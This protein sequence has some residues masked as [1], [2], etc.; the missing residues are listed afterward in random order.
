MVHGMSRAW[1]A[2]TIYMLVSMTFWKIT[3]CYPF[4]KWPKTQRCS[5]C[6][7]FKVCLAILHYSWPLCYSYCYWPKGWANFEKRSWNKRW[8]LRVWFQPSFC[9]SMDF[10]PFWLNV[11]FL[12]T[13]TTTE[14]LWFFH[15]FRGLQK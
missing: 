3:S 5:H 15:V 12:C 9:S 13:L 4:L 7:T 14:N 2:L 10:N 1:K 11:L 6:K 8:Y